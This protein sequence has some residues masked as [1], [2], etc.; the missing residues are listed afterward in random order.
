MDVRA[1]FAGVL[2]AQLA[3]IDENVLVGAPLFSVVKQAGGAPAAPATLAPSNPAPSTD[4][5]PAAA[6]A[7]GAEDL[8]TVNVPSM[9]DSISEG[10]VVTIFKSAFMCST[11]I[12]V[13]E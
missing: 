3:K 10:T 2:D 6:P 1:P 4:A 9:G 11:C 8:E 13:M 5:T 12:R 7:A